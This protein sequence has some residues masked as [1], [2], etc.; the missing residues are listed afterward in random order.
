MISQSKLLIS[1]EGRSCAKL[2]NDAADY[3]V[4]TREKGGAFRPLVLDEKTRTITS[5]GPCV[6]VETACLLLKQLVGQ[7][8]FRAFRQN[9]PWLFGINDEFA[10]RL[11]RV[12]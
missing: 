12:R 8:E 7:G 3:P 10:P 1:T 11:D 9:N 4:Y 2:L 5:G 6:A